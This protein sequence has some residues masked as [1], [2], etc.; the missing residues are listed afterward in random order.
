MRP[1]DEPQVLRACGPA[2]LRATDRRPGPGRAASR[3][4]KRR[5]PGSAPFRLARCFGRQSIW[6][7]SPSSHSSARRQASSASWRSVAACAPAA[8]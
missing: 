7:R 6:V 5:L 1:G 3:S 8:G 4:T 2:G